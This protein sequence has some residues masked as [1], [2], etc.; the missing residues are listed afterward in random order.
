MS[1]DVKVAPQARSQLLELHAWWVENRPAAATLVVDEFERLEHLLADSP[2]TGSVFE[3]R[4][5]KDVRRLRLR[6]TPYHLYYVVD[7]GNQAVLIAAVWSAMRSKGPD[8]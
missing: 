1:Y 3:R 7:E 8:I 2:N 4:K 5:G 6:G